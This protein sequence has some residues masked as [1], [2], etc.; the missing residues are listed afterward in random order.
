MGGKVRGKKAHFI[1]NTQVDQLVGEFYRIDFYSLRDRYDDH[2][3]FQWC[4]YWA[5]SRRQK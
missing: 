3:P 2:R 5:L 1:P 4:D